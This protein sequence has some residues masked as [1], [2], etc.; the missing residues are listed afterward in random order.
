MSEEIETNPLRHIENASKQPVVLSSKQNNKSDTE[1]KIEPV[2]V[3]SSI[4]PV[5]D[6]TK[7]SWEPTLNT[8]TDGIVDSI[9]KSDNPEDIKQLISGF[10]LNQSKK[11]VLRILKLNNLLDLVTEETL[12]RYQKHPDEISNK[13]LIDCMT[14]VSAQIEQ[15]QKTVNGVIDKP[16]IQINQ[17]KTEY[18]VNVVPTLTKDQR[19]NVIDVVTQIIA[20]AQQNQNVDTKPIDQTTTPIIT[21]DS[22][23]DSTPKG[24]NK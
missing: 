24:E 18:N 9:M 19:E 8:S 15:S 13:E 21:I 7:A 23:T 17:Q 4:V 14:V 22:T 6:N 3:S 10:N 5:T 12:K 11:S 2:K 1:Q 20:A 16:A